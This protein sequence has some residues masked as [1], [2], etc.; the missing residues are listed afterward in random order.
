[1]KF[2]ISCPQTGCNKVVELQNE[3][4]LSEILDKKIG[5]EIDG[6][7][8]S[9]MFAGY[10]FKITGGFDKD[11]FAMKN[12]VLTQQKKKILL[13]KG[14][15]MFRF[16]RGLHRTGIRIRK[17]V[18]GCIVSHDIKMLHIKIIQKGEKDIPGL[19]E[20]KDAKPKRLGPKRAT[21]ILKHFGLLAVYNDKKKNA[22]ER[23][24]LRYMITKF[25][26]K[27]AVETKNGKKY[28]KRAKVQRL[29]T[30]DRLRRKRVIK[31]LKKARREQ[32]EKE[33][34]AYH[35]LLKKTWTK[36]KKAEFKKVSKKNKN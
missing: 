33:K 8:I 16:R 20:E 17:L 3:D 32:T 21:K 35:E 30:P 7:L 5:D 34:K 15:S 27:R 11:G 25:A 1:M 18:R 23:K 29:I 22:E 2:N 12:G 28:E 6:G 13:H 31:A 10:K 9:D 24:N 14:D 19:T 36:A 26:P 4:K